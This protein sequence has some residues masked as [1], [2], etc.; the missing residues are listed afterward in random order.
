MSTIKVSHFHG[1]L[2]MATEQTE[3]WRLNQGLSAKFNSHL[4]QEIDMFEATTPEREREREREKLATNQIT[5]NPFKRNR[6]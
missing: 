3:Q 6:S 5:A 1:P 4:T 2:D